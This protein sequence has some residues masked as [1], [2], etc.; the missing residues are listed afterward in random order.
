MW[1]GD[2]VVCYSGCRVNPGLDWELLGQLQP[3]ATVLNPV[4]AVA[5]GWSER[6]GTFLLNDKDALCSMRH[7]LRGAS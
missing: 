7:L 6:Q 2:Q 4:H 5:D 1:V 3:A